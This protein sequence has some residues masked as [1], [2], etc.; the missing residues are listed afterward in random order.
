MER[1]PEGE[2]LRPQ[3]TL[4]L[5]TAGAADPKICTSVLLQIR[6]DRCFGGAT[7]WQTEE[8][9]TMGATEGSRIFEYNCVNEAKAF[10]ARD[11]LGMCRTSLV[12][13]RQTVL[14]IP[15]RSTKT[16]KDA[17]SIDRRVVLFTLAD[18]GLLIGSGGTAS[19]SLDTSSCSA[20]E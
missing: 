7:S 18:L 19:S 6:L 14:C 13:P 17:K 9:S 3:R 1:D 8:A 11:E 5:T 12:S 20:G 16:L 10:P 2:A 15:V 4:Y